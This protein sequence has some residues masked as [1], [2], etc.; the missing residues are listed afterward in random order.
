MKKDNIKKLIIVTVCFALLAV[1]GYFMSIEPADGELYV[2]SSAE[3]ESEQK[4]IVT[5]SGE[6]KKCGKYSVPYGSTVHDVL[7]IAGGITENAD[8]SS[9]NVGRNIF[10]SCTVN[11]PEKVYV[12]ALDE[13][14]DSALT[15]CNINTAGI[16]E[17]T[18]LKGIGETTAR[19]IINYREVYG[20]FKTPEDIMNV[21]G[22]GK[23]KYEAIKDKI[24][25]GGN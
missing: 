4:I 17:L 18:E 23:G 3:P 1:A 21:D 16:D 20:D 8:I 25:V 9:M 19:N 6:V 13:K 24:T 5:V 7:Y 11:V 15:L 22:I 10:E 14:A 12:K 2:L